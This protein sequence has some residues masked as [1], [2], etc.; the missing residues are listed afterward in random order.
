MQTMPAGTIRRCD[1]PQDYKRFGVDPHRIARFEDGRRSGDGPGCFEWWYVDATLANGAYVAALFFT[2]PFVHP[3]SAIAPLISLSIKRPGLPAETRLLP[4]DAATFVASADTCDVGIDGNT[5]RG[6]LSRYSIHANVDN[7]ELNLVLKRDVDPLR[8]GTGHLMF[9][10]PASAHFF[11]WI[12]A[13]PKGQVEVSYRVGDEWAETTGVGYHDHNWGDADMPS[14]IHDWYW[15]RASIGGYTVIAVQL[16]AQP[17]YGSA[18]HTDVVLIDPDG[19]Y[20]AKGSANAGFDGADVAPD[21]VAG[22]PVAN[23]LVFSVTDGATQYLASFVH[24]DTILRT[25]LDGAFTPQDPEASGAYLRFT[26]ACTLERVDGQGR[27][28]LG[29]PAGTTWELMWFGCRPDPQLF[30]LYA[31]ALTE[32]KAF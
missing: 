23:R 29:A 19:R 21:G 7:L 26:G 3:G 31:N 6:D 15:A 22:V 24:T 5:F 18:T 9:E 4:F 13:V 30:D 1:R 8:I 20:I 11:G 10:T 16:T 25:A 28:P 12:A 27:T 32:P 14:L 2:K 17:T